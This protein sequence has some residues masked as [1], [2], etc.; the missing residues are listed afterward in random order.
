MAELKAAKDLQEL[1]DAVSY[2]ASFNIDYTMRADELKSLIERIA[3]LTEENARLK[4]PI[5]NEEWLDNSV[6]ESHDYRNRANRS[7]V[8]ALL[9]ARSKPQ[10]GNDGK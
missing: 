6:C 9:A 4:E 3:S 7:Q 10:E 1:Y 2:N 8:N 5:S